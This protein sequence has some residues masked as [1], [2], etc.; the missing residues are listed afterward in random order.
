LSKLKNR[1]DFEPLDNGSVDVVSEA[2]VSGLLGPEDP[3]NF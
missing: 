1:G 3:L 2:G